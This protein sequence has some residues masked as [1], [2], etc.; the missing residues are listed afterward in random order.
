LLVEI[1]NTAVFVLN[2]K[3]NSDQESK[4]MSFSL[5]NSVI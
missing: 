3:G 4:T 5:I 2:C 1:V